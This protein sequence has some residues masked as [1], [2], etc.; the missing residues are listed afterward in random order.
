[1]KK[2][3]ENT[4]P[5]LASR[6]LLWFLREDLAEEVLGDLEE[7]FYT[8]LDR[9]SP[10]AAR[11]GY[12]YQVF[13]YM[14]PFAIKNWRSIFSN[15][16]TMYRHHLKIA[17]R[18]MSRNKGQFVINV[19]GLAI[20]IATCLLIVLFVADE[21]SYDRF[22]AKSD[23]I[24]RVFLKAQ[25]NG[26]FIKEAVTPAPVADAFVREY[27]EVLEATR[28]RNFGLQKAS[29]EDKVFRD[30]SLAFVDPSFFRVFTLSFVKG[31][32]ST[33]L[34][35]PNTA[36][37]TQEESVK[38]F[39]KEDPIGKVLKFE[40][41]GREFKVTG[42]IEKIP[43]NSHFHFDVFASMEGVEGADEPTWIQSNY[44]TY[45]ELREGVDPKALE[46]KIPP[47]VEKNM[48]PQLQ[49]A[50]GLSFDEFKERGNHVALLL[51]PLTAIHLHSDFSDASELEPGGD[52]NAVYIFSAIAL[53]MLLIAC[54]NFVNLS[55]AGAAKK[56]KEVGMKKLLGSEK[57]QLINGFLTES[58][59]IVIMAVSLALGIAAFNLPLFNQL[60]G[61]ELS[62]AVIFVPEVFLY[63][64]LFAIGITLL[65]GAYPAAF[66]ASFR[67]INTLKSKFAA[68]GKSKGVRS[69]LVIFQFVISAGL[70]IA[71]LVVDQQMSFIQSKPLGYD[72]DQILVLRASGLLGNKEE[73]Y[74]EQLLADPRVENIA[75]SGFI[76]AGSTFNKMSSVYPENRSE[77]IRR[78]EI[79]DVDEQYLP[80]M[81]M[82]LQTGRNFSK[83]FGAEAS[84]VIINETAARVFQLGADPIGKTIANATDNQG[85]REQLTIIGVVKDFHF[86]SLHKAI[87]PLILQMRSSNGMIIR[88]KTTDMPGLLAKMRNL[89]R[90]MK[91]DEPFDYT[92][93]DESYNQAYLT[94]QKM[95]GILR[96][97]ALLT[98]LVAC[99][100]LFGL[101]TFTTEQRVKEIGIR[102]V[103]G[104][105]VPQ[106]VQLLTKDFVRLILIAFGIAFPLGY[107]LMNK[108]L[109]GFEYRIEISWWIFVAAGLLTMAIAFLTISFHSIKSALANPVAALRSE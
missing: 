16:P 62:F 105:T 41:M 81:G 23:R 6:F 69:S 44:F 37:I 55:T 42:V 93:L 8:T 11:R 96:A 92:L 34:Q 22:H 68:A 39:G 79:Y 65:A 95:S 1:M 78:I 85:G 99:L 12:W 80:T 97:F 21:L 86:E 51:Q 91:P 24:Y 75:V 32:P 18:N 10:F 57:R 45:V 3:R 4:P 53:F 87:A 38:Y 64:L 73:A 100:G 13:Q 58:F 107:Y 102:K 43:D 84:N 88:A 72:K 56:A 76:P 71:T 90:D 35:E 98:I 101:V 36:V 59:L 103:L 106:I 77:A 54:M 74:R 5:E 83:D 40:E 94:E 63:L 27:P 61:K 66:I 46:A 50:L 15:Y 108:W 48:G 9:Q 26:E 52:I 89:W 82:Q 60:S 28:I 104:S 109:Q 29:F 70:I 14:R 17:F 49:K 30:N 47:I 20:G 19:V 31:D 7:K 2:M 25:L 33:V 67:P